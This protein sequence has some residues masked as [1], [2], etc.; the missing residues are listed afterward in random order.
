MHERTEELATANEEL[1]TANE[2]LRKEIEQR[3]N[4]ERE[5]Q[6]YA[7]RTAVFNDIIRAINEATDLPTLYKHALVKTI[8]L[9]GFQNG[10]VATA[11]GDRL[12]M[13]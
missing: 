4:A 5:A 2:E 9:L 7:H 3:I 12:D 11:S 8:E 6:K 1:R 10:F 13:Q